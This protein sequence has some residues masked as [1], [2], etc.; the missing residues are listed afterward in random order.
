MCLALSTVPRMF[1]WHDIQA[2]RELRQVLNN[3]F[4][5][6]NDPIYYSF[7]F[8]SSRENRWNVVVILVT[9][10]S[11]M[12]QHRALCVSVDMHIVKKLA[13]VSSPFY[14]F[15]PVLSTLRNRCFI[16]LTLYMILLVFPHVVK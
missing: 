15:L 3:V 8:S 16:F 7:T 14:V 9:Y 4:C 11:T 2:L 6:A 10:E 5:L 13:D 1:S 12:S